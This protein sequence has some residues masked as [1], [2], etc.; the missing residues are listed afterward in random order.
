MERYATILSFAIL[1][2][3]VA[4]SGVA[5]GQENWSQWRGPGGTGVAVAGEYPV[6]FSKSKNVK[7]KVELPGRGCSTPAV[8][9]DSIFV[10]CAIDG[11]DGL[12]CFDFDGKEKW[13]QQFGK[14]K[15]GKHRNGSGSNPSPVVTDRYVAVYYKSSTVACLTHAGEVVW[16]KNLVDEYGEDTLY[17]DRGT[18]PVL[19]AENVVIAVMQGGD[20]YLVAL[21]LDSGKVAWK[22]ARDYKVTEET[23]NAY[24]TPVALTLDG[25]ETVLVWGAGHLDAWDAKSGEK[26]WYAGDFNPKSEKFWRT[27]ASAVSDSDVAIVPFGRGKFLRA[28]KLAGADGDVTD[29]HRLWERSGVGADVPTPVLNGDQVVVLHDKGRVFCLDKFTGAEKWRGELPKARGKYFAS[30]VLAGDSVFFTREDGVI[31]VARIS[32]ETLEIRAENDMG[33]AVIATP[34]PIRNHLLV[35]GV[36]HLFLIGG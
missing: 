15:Q 33:E 6:T 1:L 34:I 22:S 19:A 14:E 16:K 21:D 13:R 27:I 4:Q 2:A 28:M 36:K 24:T 9:G 29:S 20:S 23:D 17:W 32:N 31:L 26:L 18:S 25:R 3:A 8:W 12:V 5:D 7:W 10:T 35:R 30:P 11:Q